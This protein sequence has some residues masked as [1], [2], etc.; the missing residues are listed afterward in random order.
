MPRPG[1]VVDTRKIGLLIALLVPCGEATA[2]SQGIRVTAIYTTAD[3]LASNDVRAVLQ[4]REG[5]L[6]LG[7]RDGGVSR[8]DGT[9]WTTYTREDGLASDGVIALVEDRDGRIWA[10]GGGGVSRYD[11]SRWEAFTAP[12]GLETRVVFSLSV[13]EEGVLWC[14]ANGGVLRYDAGEWSAFTVADG[15]PHSVVHAVVRT[16]DGMLWVGTRRGGLGRYDGREWTYAHPDM[17]IRGLLVDRDGG[18]WAGTASSGA[19]FHRYGEWTLF[20]PTE[21]LRPQFVDARGAVWFASDNGLVRFDGVRWSR[22]TTAAGLPDDA[23]HAA[24]LTAEGRIWVATS[25]GAAV[26]DAT[27]SIGPDT[28]HDRANRDRETVEALIAAF[29]SHDVDAMAGLVAEDVEWMSVAGDEISLEANGKG[30]LRAG[31]RSYFADYADVHAT[32]E[33]WLDLSPYVV[34]RERV[35]WTASGLRHSQ[36][37]VAVYEIEG[38]LVRRVW[39]FPA[40]RD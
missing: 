20:R 9:S 29:N 22:V 40:V 18:L 38:R 16:P 39:Y 12:A 33:A 13:D 21:G 26:L 2:Q 23:V 14:G 19:I 15:V 25:R 11:G 31:M 37:A 36:R 24:T 28:A 30:A 17:N 34:T 7:T 6:W 35:T 8:F 10:G 32:I 1:S 4:D 27:E 5:D 3:G